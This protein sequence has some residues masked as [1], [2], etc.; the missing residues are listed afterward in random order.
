MSN[1]KKK[2]PKDHNHPPPVVKVGEGVRE[3]A[4]SDKEKRE[5]PS[6]TEKEKREQTP[7]EKVHAELEAKAKDATEQH[8]QWLRLGAE[9]ENYKKRMQKEKS[10]VMQFGNESLLRAV[11][12]I[13]DNLERAI[14]HGEKMKV[15]GTLL[16]GVETIL[17]QFLA[18][19]E[20]FGV[21]PVAA[22]GESFDPEKHEAV[23]QAESDQEPD[24][25]ISELEKGYLFHERLLR[26]A[27]V[28]V[29]KALP[30]KKTETE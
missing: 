1:N 15:N 9:F 8:D 27:K 11:L 13:L 30:E 22:M 12:P 16:Q 4:P 6:S 7:L 23:S 18:I 5:G 25:V 19:L 10:D 17:R 24:R 3:K 2:D 26:P 20:R 28:L 21:K 14:D 29:S